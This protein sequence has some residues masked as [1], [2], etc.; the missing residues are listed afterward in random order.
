MPEAFYCPLKRPSVTFKRSSIV[1]EKAFCYFQEVFYHPRNGHLFL[2][3]GLL[4]SSPRPP[5]TLERPSVVLQKASCYTRKVFCCP[6]K[7]LCMNQS[8]AVTAQGRFPE[9]IPSLSPFVGTGVFFEPMRIPRNGQY[10]TIHGAR[11]HL[12]L[13]F[14]YYETAG[15]AVIPGP[16]CR[17]PS[18]DDIDGLREDCKGA[19]GGREGMMIPSAW[20][21]QPQRLMDHRLRGCKRQCILENRFS[22]C[23][24]PDFCELCYI[25]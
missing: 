17:S 1:L 11:L 5:I 22:A 24:C 7:G 13:E 19:S 3:K 18:G 12:A 10:G 15:M 25:R 20:G 21:S 23:A 14:E 16:R 9:T 4:L 6:D 8:R 2:S